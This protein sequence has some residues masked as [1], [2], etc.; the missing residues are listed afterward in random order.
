[1]TPD[2][3]G[4]LGPAKLQLRRIL[5]RQ[6][7]VAPGR[8]YPRTEQHHN[9]AA[10]PNRMNHES[11][12]VRQWILLKTLSARHYGAT[13]KE[14]AEEM[15]VGE[16]TI[17]RDLQVFRTVGFP[18]EERVGDFGRKAWWLQAAPN[19]AGMNFTF[20][21]AIALY[22]GRR[23][24]EPL[25]GTLLWDATQSAFKKIRACL[26]KTALDYVAKMAG[27][28]HQTTTGASDYSKKAEILDQVLQGIEERKATHIAY[29]SLR[30]TEPVTCDVYPYALAYHRGSLY[31][32]AHSPD[33]NEVRHY[34]VDR[35]DEAEMSQFPFQ[36]PEDFDVREHLKKSF[37]IFQGKGDVRVKVRFLPPVTRYVLE[38]KW[39]ESQRLSRQRD[40][41]VVA[42]FQ[43]SDTE[44]IKRWIMSFGEYAVV[45]EPD[46]LRQAIVKELEA[47]L[48]TYR[49]VRGKTPVTGRRRAR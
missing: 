33:H 17:R 3:P 48:Q 21:E 4:N 19:Q 28:L 8:A 35:I 27:S 31:L 39:H 12:L 13:V 40:G 46:E 9:Q 26:S 43:L 15:G 25:A 10:G 45:L 36:R 2:E 7:C 47:L 20:D 32:I 22:L 37:G 1:M 34:K 11:P 14:L 18:L 24:L 29:Q 23:F 49:D 41:S 42:E 44:E 5:A 30:S 16:K 38:S 6:P